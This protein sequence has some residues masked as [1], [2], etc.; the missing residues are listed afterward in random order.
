MAATANELPESDPSREESALAFRNESTRSLS[1][2]GSPAPDSSLPLCL[3]ELWL[4]DDD[5][6]FFE[7]F[8]DDILEDEPPT[9]PRALAYSGSIILFLFTVDPTVSTSRTEK[10]VCLFLHSKA[11]IDFTLL[12]LT[13]A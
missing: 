6:F 11:E 13:R 5:F 7:D 8:F 4:R 9:L 1:D 12:Y 10:P 2:V 3:D